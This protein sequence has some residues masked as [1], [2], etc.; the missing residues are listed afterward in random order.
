VP[1]KSALPPALQTLLLEIVDATRALPRHEQEWTLEP[2]SG[3]MTALSGDTVPVL[4]DDVSTLEN[5]GFLRCTHMGAVYGYRYVLTPMAHEHVEIIR[6]SQAVQVEPTGWAAVDAATAELGSRLARAHS[7][8]DF[9]AVGLSCES[10]LVALGRAAF[11]PAKHLPDGETE[12]SPT[13]AK[14]RLDLFIDAAAPGD[15]FAHVRKLVR[16]AWGQTQAVKHR[17]EPNRTDAGIAVDSV[18]LL[19]RIIRRLADEE[20]VSG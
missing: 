4:E 14:G 13:D 12:P 3:L 9:K 6:E 18:M 7:T 10:T 20:A 15:R 11:D 17:D 16:A 5:M 1:R 19:V 8:A 2:D